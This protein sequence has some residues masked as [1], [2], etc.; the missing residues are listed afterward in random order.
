MTH[1]I[2]LCVPT[3]DAGLVGDVIVEDG[4]RVVVAGVVDNDVD[5]V[6]VDEVDC[7][8]VDEVDCGVVDEVDCGVV[9]GVDC[10]VVDGVGVVADGVDC[11]VVDG[12]G[13]VPCWSVNNAEI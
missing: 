12:V 2:C 11:V 13:V 4:D 3:F 1:N 5:L 7:V 9:D 10:G 8:V 6:A